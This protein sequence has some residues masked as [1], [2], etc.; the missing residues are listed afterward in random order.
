MQ[1]YLFTISIIHIIKDI[2]IKSDFTP[3]EKVSLWKNEIE[4]YKGNHTFCLHKKYQ[5]KE[6]EKKSLP[7]WA[8]KLNKEKLNSLSIF[9]NATEKY[10]KNVNIKYNMQLNEG[11]YFLKSELAPKSISWC[12]SH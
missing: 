6:K 9:L 5:N 8:R 2:L 4:H 11:F 3:D 12:S 1:K 7:K 10:I